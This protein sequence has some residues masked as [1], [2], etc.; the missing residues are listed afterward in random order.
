MHI[1]GADMKIKVSFLALLLCATPSFA[2]VD[3]AS[4]ATGAPSSL[5]RVVNVMKGYGVHAAPKCDGATDDSL[6]MQAIITA[7]ASNARVL[8]P[9]GVVCRVHNLSLPSA[10]HLTIEG[11]LKAPDG[12]MRTVVNIASGADG[13]TID[14]SGVIDGNRAN[15]TVW[16]RASA[17]GISSGPAASNVVVRDVTIQH[18][19]HWP[20]NIVGVSGCTLERIVMRDGHNSPEMAAGTNNCWARH[21]DIEGIDHDGAWVFYKGVWN[22]GITDSILKNGYVSGIALYNDNGAQN[23]S[24]D[25]VIKNNEIYGMGKSC[26]DASVGRGG[27]NN[28]YHVTITGNKCYGNDTR[29]TH[30]GDFSLN[31]L[32]RSK[33]SGNSSTAVGGATASPGFRIGGTSSELEI[34]ENLILNPGPGGTLGVGFTL[35]TTGPR[36]RIE[37]NTVLDNQAT[38]TTAYGFTGEVPP[39]SVIRNNAILNTIGGCG[40][41]TGPD[42][43]TVSR[44]H[45]PCTA[46]HHMQ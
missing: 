44:I 9:K 10:S 14:G 28:H 12:P 16:P 37:N 5:T 38:R 2:D 32:E 8:I 33:I 39:N 27:T 19:L 6:A 30:L 36:I 35:A 25:I 45:K 17:G 15:A 3:G 40:A 1:R 11:T 20:L 23:L 41:L 43:T 46:S 18:V 4:A 24:H 34:T 42:A 26:I 29:G 21:L 22:S 7:A 13:V 31:A